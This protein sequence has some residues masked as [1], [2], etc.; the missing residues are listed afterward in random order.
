[1]TIATAGGAMLA[2]SEICP[3]EGPGS[4]TILIRPLCARQAT[5]EVPSVRDKAIPRLP[6]PEPHTVP[7]VPVVPIVVDPGSKRPIHTPSKLEKKD[8]HVRRRTP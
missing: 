6:A 7:T 2:D 3:E 5:E 4:D 8:S 1:M